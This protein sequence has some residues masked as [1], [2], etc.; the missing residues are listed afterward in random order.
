[1]YLAILLV[2]LELPFLG[3]LGALVVNQNIVVRKRTE[4][5][6]DFRRDGIDVFCHNLLR[7]S[8]TAS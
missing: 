8:Y 7:H 4:Q 2:G 1:M 3:A 6:G 5:L